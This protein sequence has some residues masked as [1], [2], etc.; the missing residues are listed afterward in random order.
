VGGWV[1]ALQELI[2]IAM[3]VYNG[4]L[5]LIGG[6]IAEKNGIAGQIKT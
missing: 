2:Y 4:L 5:K 6:K 1:A 3:G